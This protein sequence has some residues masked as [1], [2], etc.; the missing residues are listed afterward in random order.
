MINRDYQY[1][2][3]FMTLHEMFIEDNSL[4]LYG[5]DTDYRSSA[6]ANYLRTHARNVDVVELE[7]IPRESMKV[8]GEGFKPILLKSD[9][10]MTAFFQDYGR[11][12]IYLDVTG[13]DVQLVA[14]LLLRSNNQGYEIHVV[15][16]EPEHY[17]TEQFHKEGEDHEWAGVIDGIKPL[18]GFAN[19]ANPDEQFI[20]CVFLG[21][22]GG[23]FSHLITQMQPLEDYTIPIFGVPGFRIEYPYYAYWSNHKGMKKTDSSRNVR[24]ASA[25]SI[26]DAYLLLH[27][28][29]SDNQGKLIKV[30][31]I[32][33]KPHAVASIVYAM[34]HSRYVEVVYDNPQ[35]SE[36]RSVGVGQIFDCNITKLLVEHP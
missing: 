1:I 4:Y 23:R 13:M 33:T 24:Y 34:R 36:K 21:F 2:R 6:C 16:A 5:H 28:I 27:K 35:K 22:E 7:F 9:K 26:V 8:V 17:I 10:E 30:A 20:F 18:P 29:G 32:G 11:K 15:Y 25:N 19:F 31:P 14:A 3:R 12:H